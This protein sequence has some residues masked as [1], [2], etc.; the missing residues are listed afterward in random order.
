MEGNIMMKMIRWQGLIAFIGI[1]IVLF[2]FWFL[3]ID[4]LIERA[5]ETV[6]THIVGAKV[7][8]DTADLTVLPLGLALKRLQVTNPDSPMSN[9]VEI[10]RIAFSMDSANLFLRKVIIEEM[11]LEGLQLNTPRKY[12]GAVKRKPKGTP[13]VSD[14]TKKTTFQLPVAEL[15]DIQEILKKEEL[16]SLKQIETLRTDIEAGKENWQKRLAELPDE[17]TFEQYKERIEKIRKKKSRDIAGGL[18]I[19]GEIA[20]I[21]KE[22]SRDLKRIE[23]A[24]REFSKETKSLR[25]RVNQLRN[26]PQEDVRRIMDTYG[27]STKGLENISQALFGAKVSGYIQKALVWYAKLKPV[28]ER[29]RS[30]KKGKEVVK[31]MRGKGVN[32]RFKEYEPLPEFLIRKVN[33][34]LKLRAGDMAGTIH[35]ITFDQ[36]IIGK[37]LD[38]NFSGDRLKG[39]TSAKINGS[40]NHIVPAKNRDVM[41][42]L[43]RGY[44][45]SDMNLSESEKM[46]ISLKKGS[47]DLKLKAAI[48]GDSL[49]AQLKVDLGSVKIETAKQDDATMIVRALRSTLSDVSRFSVQADITGTLDDYQI[50]L[51]SDLDRVLS[52]ALGKQVKKQA[53][54]FENKLKSA[55]TEKVSGP[56]KETSESFRGLNTIGDEVTSRLN[57]GDSILK[58][59]KEGLPGGLKLPF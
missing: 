43:I 13:S 7:E 21:Q 57:M 24:Q 35:N 58:D 45:V 47:A 36:D 33:A 53:R 32:V 15:P 38:F 31:P 56:M 23:T 34:T 49:A 2:V 11:T 59:S 40:L 39:I 26:A 50:K 41:N 19:A 5:I 42:I 48:T 25:K 9:A 46:P 4:F 1:I 18:E 14:K 10:E 54:A 29:Q 28:I 16:H 3:L 52:N 22:L 27:L 37:P 12:S 8:L 20:K 55:I 44:Q 17:K 30:E 51:S 6:G